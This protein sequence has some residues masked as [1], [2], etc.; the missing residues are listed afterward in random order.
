VGRLKQG[1]IIMKA[2]MVEFLNDDNSWEWFK[3]SLK[4]TPKEAI[5]DYLEEHDLDFDKKYLN[6]R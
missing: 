2:V 4:Q 3:V 5:I 6:T 1:G